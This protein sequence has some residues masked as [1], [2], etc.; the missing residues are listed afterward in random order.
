MVNFV[1]LAQEDCSFCVVFVTRE[2]K[3]GFIFNYI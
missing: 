1:D 3:M 2:F